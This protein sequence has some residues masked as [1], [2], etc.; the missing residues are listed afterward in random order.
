MLNNNQIKLIQTAVRK[1][2]LR[3][4]NF[5][6]RYR[7]LL[8]QY[9]QPDDRKVTTCRQLNN[10]QMED[11][12]A[13]CESYGWRMP[14]KPKDY[15]RQRVAKQGELA[16]FAQQSAIR[17]LAED[18][19]WSVEHLE[20]FIKRMTEKDGWFIKDVASLTPQ[21]AHKTIEALKAIL[22]RETGKE[23]SNLQEIK[24]DMEVATD[25]KED[26]TSQIA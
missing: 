13:I 22:G 6:G 8:G 26:K 11:L 19:G 18:L 14:G 2:G 4:A 5:D 15:Y 3:T 16:S 7:L 21:F 23:Y 10:W 9:K 24:E 12:L 20:G 25:G 1:A 17:H